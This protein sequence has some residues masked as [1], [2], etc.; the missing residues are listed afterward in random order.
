MNWLLPPLEP[1][2]EAALRDVRAVGLP[3]RV[4]AAQRLARPE[5]GRANEA[6]LSLQQLARD[7]EPAV[8]AAALDSLATLAH[9]DDHAI[10]LMMIDDCDAR[11]REL[12][13]IALTHIEHP[14]RSSTL[15]K[16]LGHPAP[17]VRFQAL[18]SCGALMPEIVFEQALALSSDPDPQLRIASIR[19]LSAPELTAGPI[20]WRLLEML[21]DGDLEVRWEAALA[22]APQQELEALGV[23][24]AGL[25]R[26]E[27]VLD[28]LD[29]LG[30]YRAPAALQAVQSIA[31][32]VLK[33]PLLV[34]VACRTLLAMGERASAV[35][36]LRRVL[37]A[38]RSEGRNLALQTIAQAHLTE[39]GPELER[40]SRWRRGLDPELL[41]STLAAVADSCASARHTLTRLARREDAVGDT[42]RLALLGGNVSG[43]TPPGLPDPL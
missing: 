43:P 8:R 31:D 26:R 39:L 41:V 25:E 5:A 36:G 10:A 32:S 28:T 1:N 37:R 15:Q 30:P 40:L 13:V 34:A 6:R 42:A 29:A 27:H 2:F 35:E 19:A 22:L 4:A 11:V 20:R 3:A 33:S 24:L 38:F 7:P 21:A 14:S 18:Q 16:A 9:P 12:A 17:E 23:L